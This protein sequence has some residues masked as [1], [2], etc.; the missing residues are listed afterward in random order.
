[1]LKK[2]ILASLI[3]AVCVPAHAQ[4]IISEYI[5]GSSNNKAIEL[6]NTGT[7]TINLD[8]YALSYYFNGKTTAGRTINL[9]GSIAANTTFVIAHTSATA[10]L[11]NKAQLLSGGSW[12]NGDDAV[13]LSNA[14]NTIDSLGQKGVDPGSSWSDSGVSTKDRT[15][16]RISSISQGDSDDS[17]AFIPSEQ[18]TAL[19]KDDFSNIGKHNNEQ[20]PEP[21]TLTCN[22]NNVLISTIQ[23]NTDESPLLGEYVEI[24]GVITTALQGDDQLKGFFIQEETTQYDNDPLT[25]EGIFVAYTGST[26]TAG[27]V[28][29]LSGKVHEE[30]GQTQ[31][32]SVNGIANCGTAPVSSTDITMPVLP[33]LE[34]YEGMLVN[35]TNELIVNDTYGLKRYGEVKLASERLYQ[36]T[37][38]ALPGEP[39]NA[40]EVQ[41]KQKELT[42]DD[43]ISTQ[44]P[45]VI[46][47]PTPELDAYN[48]MRLGDKVNNIQGVLGFGYG[49]YRIHPVQQPNFI[50][51]NLRTEAPHVAERGDLRIASFNVLN[52]FNGDGQ[53][54]GF[55]TP[56]GAD[57][58]EEFDR[59]KA[60]IITAMLDLDADIIGILEMENDGFDELSALADLTSSLNAQDSTNQYAYVNLNTAQ[61]GGDAIMS[62][63]IYRSNK[64]K[65]IGNPSFTEAEPF[66]YGNRPPV[67][68]T[69]ESLAS[70]EAFNVV[71]THLRSKGSCSRAE[72]LDQDQNDG[73]GCWNLTRINAVKAL[74]AWVSTE[75]TGISD[76]D[77]LILG[78]IN[79]YAQEDP[80][81]TFT[82]QGYTN[83]KQQLNGNTADYSYVYK[84]RIGS[85]DHAFASTELMNKVIAVSDWHINA[86]EPAAL[87]YNT[88]Y[89]SDKHKASLYSEHAYRSSDHDPIVIELNT[90]PAQDI[91]E[92]EFTDINGWLW[93]QRFSIE[94]PEGYNT[95]EVNIEGQG[96]A[97][98]YVRHNKKPYFLSFD[99]RPYLWGSNEQCTLINAQS[100]TWHF[101]IRGIFPYQN[102]TLKYKATK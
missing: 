72:G 11:A 37:Q 68:Q 59:Q 99:C 21:P 100:G 46:P 92:G 90:T 13:I 32:N 14:G 82:E 31:I 45:E 79:A 88:E 54:G 64:V 83:I 2:A 49:Q 6:Y 75:P 56:R 9:E 89:K 50:Q 94:L 67:M 91:I 25:S 60:K 16:I 7:D 58:Q 66:D 85:L 42:L 17:D 86:D 35:V 78:D 43:G 23:G 55:P 87:D 28:I 48:T 102:V 22:E 96:E 29:K 62:A 20:P 63:L 33:S 3:S 71:I 36:A 24:Q 15:L 26:V 95:L 8:G 18:W 41:N 93:W 5:E 70:Q 77:T 39:A 30:Y 52:Y 4:L 1:M 69:F 65:E 61:V 80:I 38:L 81:R 84:G 51:Q 27:D 40:L 74:S 44:N 34:A 53:G 19:A 10:E 57:T 97:D 98:L 73:Q 47:Y 101:G 12:Y 76:P